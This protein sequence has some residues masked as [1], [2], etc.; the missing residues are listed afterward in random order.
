M[1]VSLVQLNPQEDLKSAL[2]QAEDQVRRAAE[3]GTDLILLPEYFAFM[4]SDPAVHKASGQWFPEIDAR[5]SALARE[6]GVVVHVGSVV[7]LRGTETYNTGT[8]Y[9]PDGSQLARYSKIHLFDVTLPNGT[10]FKESSVVSPGCDVVTYRVKDW[11]VGC[12]ICYDVRFPTL[13]RRLRDKGAELILVPAAFTL[14]TGKDHWEVLLRARAIDTGCYVAAAGHIGTYGNGTRASWGH[15]LVA[16][17]W[18]QVITQ[19]S[20][21]IGFATAVIDKD[22]LHQVRETLPVHRHHVLD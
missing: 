14:A 3:G 15:S 17:P 11:T 22:Y 9:G 1:R 6:V 20:E 19:C 8:A 4:A 5:M 10:S 16:D 13:Y 7:E 21:R 2:Q 12:T 18:G